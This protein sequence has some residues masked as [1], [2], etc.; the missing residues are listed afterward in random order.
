LAAVQV[1]TKVARALSIVTRAWRVLARPVLLRAIALGIAVGIPA[2]VL[3][4]GNGLRAVDVLAWLHRSLPVR[5][6]LWAGWLVL[7]APAMRAVFVAPGSISLRA[8]RLPR[9]PLLLALFTLCAAGQVPWVV[10]FARGAGWVAAW[11]ALTSSI[12]LGALAVSAWSRPRGGALVV[13]T[14]GA[15]LVAWDPMP[16]VVA[17]LATISLPFALG[18]A[19]R[20]ALEQPGLRFKFTRP[21]SALAALYT[22][23]VL[24]LLRVERS[25]LSAAFGAAAAGSAGVVLSL[26][27]DPTERPVQRALTVMAL[28]LTVAAAVCVAP[29]LE[30][31][32]RLHAQLRSLRVRQRAV[33]SGFLLA[34]VT[35][36]S[37]LA[38]TSSVVLSASAEL[39][40]A[41]LSVALLCWAMALGCAIALWG[42]FLERR[43]PRGTGTFVA[44]VTL[45][46]VLAT[47]GASAW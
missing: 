6:V 41:S 4:A 3:S 44:G 21:G 33:V 15:L 7:S 23:H 5:C 31:E 37:A 46:A 38:A 19:L 28:P 22:V 17:A 29:L 40:R 2:F 16:I 47:L 25:R 12:A 36:S 43:S 27:N 39:G 34:V 14:L 20:H 42:R 11:G 1:A 45:L 8:L 13:G 18:A 35:P 30:N 32:R 24:R 10:L 26:H 9:V